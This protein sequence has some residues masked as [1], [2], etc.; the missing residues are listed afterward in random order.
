MHSLRGLIRDIRAAVRRAVN[1][2]LVVIFIVVGGSALIEIWPEID[3]FVGQACETELCCEECTSMPV[4]RIIDGDT[5]VSGRDRVRLYGLDTPEL[6]QPCAD[7]ATQRARELAGGSVR[8]EG[9]PRTR[10]LYGRRLYYVYTEA[11]ESIAELLV[12]EGLA[13]AWTADGQHRDHLT[14][15]ESDAR[16]AGVGCLW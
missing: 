7:A 12:R 1:T 6:G 3:R 2:A 5:F 15:V 9:G 11:G 8:V 16:E 10:D 4:T 14:A 13:W